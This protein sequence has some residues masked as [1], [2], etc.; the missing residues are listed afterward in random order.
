MRKNLFLLCFMAAVAASPAGLHAQEAEP[1]PVTNCDGFLS[2]SLNSLGS[3][4]FLDFIPNTLEVIPNTLE[5]I[6]AAATDIIT[7]VG[8]IGAQRRTYTPPI[9]LTEV[10]SAQY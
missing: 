8:E 1:A 3:G 9:D 7:V 5:P 10:L 6:A 2:C 4:S